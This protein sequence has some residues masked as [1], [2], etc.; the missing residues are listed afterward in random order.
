LYIVEC[1]LLA[2]KTRSEARKEPPIAL[3]TE[4]SRH[5]GEDGASFLRDD[6]EPNLSMA[7]NHHVCLPEKAT[8][9]FEQPVVDANCGLNGVRAT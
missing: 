4:S 6:V 8:L 3:D 9:D 1:L 5:D 2:R 7:A